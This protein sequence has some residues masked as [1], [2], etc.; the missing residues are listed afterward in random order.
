MNVCKAKFY[1]GIS[2]QKQWVEI[3]HA[4]K[5]EFIIKLIN[6]EQRA[7]S[8]PD[9]QVSST[10]GSIPTLIKLPDGGS[11]ELPST[12]EALLIIK[13]LK[14]NRTD[15][16]H[17]IESRWQLVLIACFAAAVSVFA[18]F[19]WAVPLTVRVVQ[20]FISY[21]LKKTLGNQAL[22]LLDSKFLLPSEL[23]KETVD[24]KLTLTRSILDQH[25]NQFDLKLRSTRPP[26]ANALA[27]LPET[28]ILTDELVRRLSAEEIFAVVAHEI[29]H[30][31][32]DHGT[33]ALLQSTLL[34]TVGFSIFGASLMSP[35][36]LQILAAVVIFTRYTR[37][38]EKE[39]DAFAVSL[40]SEKDFSPSILKSALKK[41]MP[42]EIEEQAEQETGFL[43][44]YFSTHPGLK[45]RIELIRQ[46]GIDIDQRNV[47]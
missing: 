31:A 34:T 35:D 10:V 6:D 2:S 33:R 12:A 39:A 5:Q 37:E 44:T 45:E 46:R 30:L 24:E 11:L 23:P 9:L 7:Y 13:E 43:E 3:I 29:G 36:V 26:M 28:I 8:S 22:K 47:R 32:H 4:D 25:Y 1:D 27:V 21:E 18:V 16:L 38:H 15:W 14:N 42:S 40:L 20:P 17:I 19:N 41:I